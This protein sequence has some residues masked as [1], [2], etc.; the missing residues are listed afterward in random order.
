MALRTGQPS[1]DGGIRYDRKVISIDSEEYAKLKEDLCFCISLGN[2]KDMETPDNLG[3]FTEKG[4]VE[5]LPFKDVSAIAPF[6]EKVA[7]R[8]GNEKPATSVA[9]LSPIAGAV[10]KCFPTEEA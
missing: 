1:E 10:G 6:V 5:F 9:R 3:V 7:E 2:I 4:K 8:N